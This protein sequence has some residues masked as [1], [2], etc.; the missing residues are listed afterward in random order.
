FTIFIKLWTFF[1]NFCYESI[2][3]PLKFFNIVYDNICFIGNIILQYFWNFI[4]LFGFC[5]EKVNLFFIWI[6]DGF[7]YYYLKT[8][9][10]VIKENLKINEKKEIINHSSIQLFR[11]IIHQSLAEERIFLEQN[12]R[13]WIEQNLKIE[14]KLNNFVN[15]NEIDN[16]MIQFEDKIVNLFK[17]YIIEQEKILE[18]IKLEMEEKINLFINQKDEVFYNRYIQINDEI[19][20]LKIV[21]NEINEKFNKGENNENEKINKPIEKKIN[22]LDEN[23]LMKKVY[24]LIKKELRLYEA[25]HTGMPDFAL[26]SSGYG[27]SAGECWAFYGGHGFL[28]I[29]LSG[30]INVTAVSYEHLPIELS[31]DGHIKTAP[32]NFLSYQDIDNMLSRMLLGNF[33]YDSKGE[34]LQIFHVQQW[35][36]RL[37]NIIE[38]ETLTNWGSYV[39]CLYRFRVHGDALKII[40]E[41]NV[42]SNTETFKNK[43]KQISNNEIK[44]DEKDLI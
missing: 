17:N 3:F 40:P 37:T 21:Q 13:K 6:Y 25:D 31:P 2:Q 39:T 32:K 43:H 41:E 35:D 42:D 23:I 11:K 12:I 26:E 38:L 20:Y 34:P 14:L 27:A 15:K 5:G 22:E 8:T 16:R 44:T 33:T 29:G 36:S 19:K 7:E 30:R 18:K 24:D 10:N 1:N 9:K 4:N 28:T